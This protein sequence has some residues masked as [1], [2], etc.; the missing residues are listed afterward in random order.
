ME[1]RRG[2]PGL[3]NGRILCSGPKQVDKC[4]LDNRMFGRT[5]KEVDRWA[6][7]SRL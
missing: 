1:E 4:L 5:R 3:T 2:R 6:G 7:S